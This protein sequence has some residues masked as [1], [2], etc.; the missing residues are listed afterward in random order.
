MPN[1][2]LQ[3]IDNTVYRLE[4][5][6]NIDDVAEVLADSHIQ[7][8]RIYP[9]SDSNGH[10]D[11]MI[12]IFLTLKY[13]FAPIVI[14]VDDRAFYITLLSREDTNDLAKLLKNLWSLKLKEW[15]NFP[16]EQTNLQIFHNPS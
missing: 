2:I 9:F 10:T 4:I 15:R 7:F 6:K 8:E 11:R 1:L 3:W 14:N 12:T 16:S 5:A 13:I